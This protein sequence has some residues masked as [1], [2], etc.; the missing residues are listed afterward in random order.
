MY[1]RNSN[2][3]M[4]FKLKHCTC[5][6]SQVLGTHTN[7]QLEILAINVMSCIVYFC[8]II[9][10]GSRKKFLK[11]PSD[12]TRGI[13]TKIALEWRMNYSLWQYIRYFNACITQWAHFVLQRI[14]AWFP[15]DALFYLN[16]YCHLR[17][18]RTHRKWSGLIWN[19]RGFDDIILHAQHLY[20]GTILK[21]PIARSNI[22]LCRCGLASVC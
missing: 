6:Q 1:C 3:H 10:E 22:C 16:H 7:F 15:K 11:Q 18:A 21:I 14:Q 4:N 20:A 12:V 13:I 5:A 8:D 19:R 9:L 17:Q 2:S